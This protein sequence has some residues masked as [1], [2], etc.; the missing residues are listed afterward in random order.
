MAFNAKKWFITCMIT[1]FS[2]TALLLV[3]F[4][5][6]DPYFHFHKPFP[7]VSYR[8]YDERYINDGISR[9]FD[10][11]LIITGTS[12]A[13]NF[14]TSEADV[15]FGVKSVKETF[16]GAAYKEI[17]ENL[18]RALSRN[19]DLKTI[20]WTMDTN[21]ILRDKDYVAYDEYP[22]YLYDDNPWNDVNYVFNKEVWYHGVLNNLLMTITG[23]PSTTFDEYSSWEKE[24][25]YENVM[26]SYDRWEE[27]APEAP[28]LTEADIEM[29]TGN[30]RQNFVDLV[31]RYPD[32]TFYIFYTPYSI[33]WWDF[34]NQEGMI[35]YYFEAELIT[36][37][38][39]LE[40]PNVKLYNFHDRYDII[41][42][43]D[44][45][46]DKEHY[47]AHVNSMILEWMAAGDGLVT[48]EN[49]MERYEQER[50]YYLNYDYEGIF[51]E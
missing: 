44:N 19:K 4:W 30:I 24:T 33:C 38:M 1:L 40:C 31:N 11:D 9:H 43:L 36:T 23:Q 10:Y 15:L 48:K 32:T 42:D 7:F 39:L 17:S 46:R 41:T 12:M 2:V 13:Q 26:A 27:K 18:E 49:Y 3:V 51:A 35:N 29:V 37:E 6:F 25:G 20:I 5:I 34:M 14:K 21:A 45:Y 8:L 50:Q 16:S 47:A 22:V 28:G